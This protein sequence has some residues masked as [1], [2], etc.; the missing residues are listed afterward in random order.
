MFAACFGVLISMLSW[1]LQGVSVNSIFHDYTERVSDVLAFFQLPATFL[2]MVL[3]GNVHGGSTGEHI[4]WMLVVTE[5]S[6]AGFLLSL[7]WKRQTPK[8]S[9]S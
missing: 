4:Y 6:L 9:Q 1:M 3:T 7:L 8:P 5:W 2:A